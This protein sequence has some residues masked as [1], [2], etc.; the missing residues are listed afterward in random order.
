MQIAARNSTHLADG[1]H[2]LDV[3][4]LDVEACGG[5]ASF[6]FVLVRLELG[7]PDDPRALVRLRIV[8]SQLDQPSK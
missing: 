3:V 8:L 7:G 5:F 1:D 6:R 2:G 4:L